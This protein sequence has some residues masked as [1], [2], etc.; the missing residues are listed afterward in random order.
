MQ[1]QLVFKGLN[2]YVIV[3]CVLLRILS[4]RKATTRKEHA[5]FSIRKYINVYEFGA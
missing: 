3:A 5:S 2:I 4:H 1:S